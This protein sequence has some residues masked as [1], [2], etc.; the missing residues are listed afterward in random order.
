MAY[1]EELAD[2]IRDL[3]EGEPG[4]SEKR[5]FG[6]LAFLVNGNMAVSASSQRR[7]SGPTKCQ[8]GRMTWVRT[9]SPTSKARSMSAST[10]PAVRCA[11]AHLAFG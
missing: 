5:M 3:V 2:R 11:R 6:G 4:L 9:I 7:S 1:D 8:V 10:A